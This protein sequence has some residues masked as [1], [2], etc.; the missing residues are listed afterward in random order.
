MAL[1][2]SVAVMWNCP[3]IG[4]LGVFT[5][6]RSA[7]RTSILFEDAGDMLMFTPHLQLLAFELGLQNHL[8]GL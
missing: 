2:S 6:V 3:G 1:R 4:M 5:Q 7:G 8:N